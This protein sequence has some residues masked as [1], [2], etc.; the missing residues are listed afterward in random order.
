MCNTW[1]A[2]PA[3]LHRFDR[4]ITWFQ[5]RWWWWWIHCGASLSVVYIF[6]KESFFFFSSH[7]YANGEKWPELKCNF[8]REKPLSLKARFNLNFFNELFIFSRDLKRWKMIFFSLGR[9]FFSLNFHN[10]KGLSPL[11]TIQ[12]GKISFFLFIIP[13]WIQFNW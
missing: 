3:S 9:L 12:E 6:I 8:Q 1:H 5:D 7:I 2:Y 13:E 10:Y 4:L 11:G